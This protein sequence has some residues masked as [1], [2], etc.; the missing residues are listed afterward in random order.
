MDLCAQTQFVNITQETTI[1]EFTVNL[2]EFSDT[3]SERYGI[4]NLCVKKLNLV[5]ETGASAVSQYVN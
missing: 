5:D 2:I 4:A 3:M 1:D